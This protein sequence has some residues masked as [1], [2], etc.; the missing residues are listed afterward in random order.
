MISTNSEIYYE[1]IRRDT[2][3]YFDPKLKL[4][5]FILYLEMF[6]VC[7]IG[8]SMHLKLIFQL[9]PLTFCS[10]EKVPF[11]QIMCL[12]ELFINS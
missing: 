3:K 8:N 5:K 10:K 12:T 11:A 7:T 2:S 4:S 6:D 9:Y 1:A